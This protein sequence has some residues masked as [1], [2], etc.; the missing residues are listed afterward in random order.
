[1]AT[2]CPTP[3][4]DHSTVATGSSA[5][6]ADRDG[7]SF[8]PPCPSLPM[9]WPWESRESDS[10]PSTFKLDDMALL[11]HW[12][13]ST[14]LDM[15]RSPNWDHYWQK[16]FPEVAFRHAFVMH[17]ILS[18]AAL[19]LACQQP[20]DRR[21]LVCLAAHHHTIGLHGFQQGI[22]GMSDDNSDALFICTSLNF[23]YVLAIF[24][25]LCD[26]LDADPK[27]RI[28][29][30]E[31]IP[32]V[33]GVEAVLQPIYDR[34]R[35][36][37]LSPLLDL[38][39]WD[40]LDPDHQQVFGDASFDNLKDVWS[41]SND[42]DVYDK[43]LYLLRKC[44]AHMRQYENMSSE[45]LSQRGYNQAWSAPFIWLHLT[46]KEYFELL[47]QRQ[48]PAL[49]IFAYFGTLFHF[50]DDY[51]FMQ[52]WGWNMVEVANELLGD[53]WSRWTAWPREVVGLYSS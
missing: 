20:A 44:N 3:S 2:P 22:A 24:G 25:P 27:S 21:Q 35:L 5:P 53:Y 7:A 18:L 6:Q 26:S 13:L 33:R 34:V 43:A 36:G 1:M 15:V 14:S 40:Q 16:I 42:A 49:L 28:L 12:T 31:W 30:A 48:P 50:L 29:G 38:G 46:P 19:H 11:H 32:A 4:S 23:V 47:Q 41:R 17:G 10:G 39:N 52:G 8:S 37:P 45:A 51:W 9:S